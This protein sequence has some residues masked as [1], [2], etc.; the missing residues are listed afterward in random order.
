M[1]R[2]SPNNNHGVHLRWVLG[3]KNA[4]NHDYKDNNGR[5][6]QFFQFSFIDFVLTDRISLS[7][8]RPKS[9]SGK[10]SGCRFSFS[11][12]KNVNSK[13]IEYVTFGFCFCVL[14]FPLIEEFELHCLSAIRIFQFFSR[15]N[16]RKFR[17]TTLVLGIVKALP[18]IHQPDRVAPKAGDVSAAGL[19]YQHTWKNTKF[20]HACCYGFY[21]AVNPCLTPHFMWWS[22]LFNRSSKSG[23]VALHFDSHPSSVF[24]HM[25]DFG[26]GDGG[27]TTVMKINGNKVTIYP[28]KKFTVDTEK[29]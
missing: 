16:P 5:N 23:E 25:G 12:A 4:L 3:W 26:C 29:K 11:A 13:A 2:Q 18:F 9:V 7:G 8:K 27:W 19:L 20:F 28:R 22:I 1:N 17:Q 6:F 21:R 15:H 24:C 10:S 14:V